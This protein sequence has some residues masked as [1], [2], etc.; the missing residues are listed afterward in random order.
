MLF[1]RRPSFP[2]ALSASLTRHSPPRQKVRL[3]RQST[4]HSPQPTSQRGDSSVHSIPPTCS[5]V[6]GAKPSLPSKRMASTFV[7]VG[8]PVLAN[9]RFSSW[10]WFH[11]V[12]STLKVTWKQLSVSGASK[13]ILIFAAVMRWEWTQRRRPLRLAA[14][15]DSAPRSI[16]GVV[17]SSH[18]D[19]GLAT[20]DIIAF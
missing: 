19:A 10:I 3:Y 7:Q 20:G 15:G 1:Q 8:A 12:H 6:G 18:F 16:T 5:T 13:A 14:C 17:A 9:T 4:S 2:A 11:P